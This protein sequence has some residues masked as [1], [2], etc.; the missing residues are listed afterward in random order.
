M[1]YSLKSHGTTLLDVSGGGE[2]EE[3][4]TS[5][6]KLEKGVR[7]ESRNSREFVKRKGVDVF[8]GDLVERSA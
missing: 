8:L 6:T 7:G 3:Q 2:N 1:L 5:V 4:D